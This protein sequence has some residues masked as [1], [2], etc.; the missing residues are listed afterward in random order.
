MVYDFFS[1]LGKTTHYQVFLRV[2][3]AIFD[4]FLGNFSHIENGI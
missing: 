3:L 1:N 4:F 2:L